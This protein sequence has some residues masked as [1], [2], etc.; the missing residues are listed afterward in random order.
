MLITSPDPPKRQVE[1]YEFKFVGGDALNVRVDKDRGDTVDITSSP[2]AIQIK[3]APKS[4]PVNPTLTVKAQEVTILYSNLLAIVK[5]YA[6]VTE[7]TTEQ[8][9]EWMDTF[10][11]P[12]PFKM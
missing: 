5:E 9:Q 11:K 12:S 8:Q 1:D 4:S 10:A 3:I 7:M 6:D 2:V